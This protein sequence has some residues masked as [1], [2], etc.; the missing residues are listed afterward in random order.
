MS[1]P[2]STTRSRFETAFSIALFAIVAILGLWQQATFLSS[3]VN[4][5]SVTFF[6]IAFLATV[7]SPQK[8]FILLAFLLPISPAWHVQMN[9]IFLTTFQAAHHPGLD[10]T[11]GFA[12]GFL[13]HRLL[14]RDW[15]IR[16][17]SG[18]VWIFAAYT[19]ICSSAL[20]SIIRNL[21]Q[22]ASVT[23]LSGIVFNLANLRTLSWHDDFFPLKDLF[24]YSLAFAAFFA[25]FDILSRSQRKRDIVF[26]PIILSSLVVSLFALIQYLF[27]IGVA[28]NGF[29]RGVDSFFPDLHSL[30]GFMLIPAIGSFLYAMESKNIWIRVLCGVASIAAFATIIFAQSRFTF[31]IAIAAVSF[32]LLRKISRPKNFKSILIYGASII[33]VIM[34]ALFGYLKS[35]HLQQ[36]LMESIRASETLQ[37]EAINN[38]LSYR[39]ELFL[40]AL[41]M[42]SSY[43]LFGLG[44]GQFNRSSRIFE[45]AHSNSLA[46]SGGENA[47]NYFLQTLAELG[48]VGCILIGIFLILPL[49]RNNGGKLTK[50]SFLAIVAIFLGN[51]YAH[52]LLEREMLVI[53]AIFVGLYFAEAEHAPWRTWVTQLKSWTLPPIK[54]NRFAMGLS[55]LLILGTAEIATSFHRMPYHFGSRC[56]ETARVEPDGWTSGLATIQVPETGKKIDV[57]YEVEGHKFLKYWP[58]FVEYNVRDKDQNILKT[59]RMQA[60]GNSHI[61]YEPSATQTLGS[62]DLRVSRCLVPKNVGINGDPRHLGINIKS[63]TF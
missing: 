62:I 22:S 63:M 37:F 27:H 50:V 6:T 38:A 49:L 26:I 57:L 29:S 35:G 52:S 28:R 2:I 46:A 9:A 47:H 55:V 12:T 44:Q 20:L 41:R 19:Y 53:L 14:R 5:I 61:V 16:M 15:N 25:V 36:G 60:N 23:N 3:H 31:L 42:F 1:Q 17:P 7:L 43:P 56:F 39:P 13:V 8:G 40:A 33:A 24:A 45:F 4:N 18:S 21:W 58:V 11:S 48:L 30:A 59:E 54:R 34:V 32:I 10:L 51:I